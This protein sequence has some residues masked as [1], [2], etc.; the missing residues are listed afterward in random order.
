MMSDD[1][2]WTPLALVAPLG[3]RVSGALP[4]NGVTGVS[5]DTRTLQPGDLFVALK[6]DN[7]DG[8]DHVRKAFES[9]AAAALIDEAHADALAGA[10]PLYVAQDTLAALENLGRASRARSKARIVAVTGSVGKTTTKELLR[11][12]LESRARRMPRPP[13][14]TITGA[15]R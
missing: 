8:H 5:I 4:A 2:L 1:A 7:S 11:V 13:P 3:A 10:G 15:C 14:T 12:A 9:G 6:G